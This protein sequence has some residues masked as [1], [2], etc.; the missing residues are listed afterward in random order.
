MTCPLDE[1]A[2]KCSV[3]PVLVFCTRSFA[4]TRIPATWYAARSPHDVEREFSRILEQEDRET[5]AAMALE[6][7][8][9]PRDWRDFAIEEGDGRSA[10]GRPLEQPE[11]FAAAVRMSFPASRLGKDASLLDCFRLVLTACLAH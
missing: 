2:L 7:L 9:F 3:P 5:A 10:L 1:Y 4:T 6:L 11:Q 8:N